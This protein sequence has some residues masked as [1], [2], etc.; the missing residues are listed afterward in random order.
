MKPRQSLSI[1]PVLINKLRPQVKSLKSEKNFEKTEILLSPGSLVLE[2][3]T[4]PKNISTHMVL[5][6]M[7]RIA[8]HFVY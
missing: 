3:T 5:C 7:A 1:Q 2:V 4:F 8:E 6:L